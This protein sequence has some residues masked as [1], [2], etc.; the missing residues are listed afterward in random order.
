MALFVLMRSS[1]MSPSNKFRHSS[2]TL[3]SL[4]A[5]CL[6]ALGLAGCE[7]GDRDWTV[8]TPTPLAAALLSIDGTSSHDVWAVGADKGG[9]GPL[10]LHYDGTAWSTVATHSLGTLWWVHAFSDGTVY[11]AGAASTILRWDGKTWTR[12]KT[13]GLAAHTVFGLW[14]RSPNDAYAVGSVSGR[15]G[16]VWHYDGTGWSVVEVPKDLPGDTSEAPGFFK[17]CG[18]QTDVWVVGSHGNLLHAA[19]GGTFTAVKTPTTQTLFTVAANDQFM[20][21]V[22]GAGLGALI[23]AAPL[24]PPVDVTPPDAPLIQG[25]FLRPDGH[26]VASGADGTMYERVGGTWRR[27]DTGI[28]TAVQSLHAAWIDPDGGVWAVG[29]GVLSPALDGGVIFHGGSAIATYDPGSHVDGGTDLPPPAVCPAARIDPTPD[30][31]IARRWNEQILGA[32]RTDL[33]RPGVHARNLF[34]LS[35]AMWDAWAAYD[36]VADG[37]FVNERLTATDV[38][39][40]RNEAM[41]YAAYRV[42]DH[43]YAKQTGGAVSSA[44]FAAFMTKLGYDPADMS[45]TGAT[46]R[47]LGNRIGAAIIAATMNDGANEAANYADTTGWKASNP[48]LVID[49][50]GAAMTDPDHWQPLNIN[51]AETQNGIVIPSGVQGYVGSNWDLVTPFAM[52]RP[53]PGLPYYDPGAA[54][55]AAQPEMKDWLV[56]VIRR[57]AELDATDG[58]MIDTSPGA[59]GNNPLGTNDGHGRTLNPVTGQAY[60]PQMVARGD[61][62]RVLAEFWADGPKSETPPGHWNVL[63][64][65][66]V[67][68]ASFSRKLGGTGESLSPLEWDTKMYLALNSAVH[69]AAIT[70]WGIKRLTTCAR[71]ISLIRYL[72]GLGQASDPALPHYDAKGLPLVPGLVELITAESSAPGQRHAQL[73]RH[74]GELAV[75]GWRGEPGDRVN[76]VSG[77]AWIRALE[78]MPYQR[79]TFVTPAFPGFTSGHSTFSRAAAEVLTILTGSEFFP[80]GLAEFVAMPGAL[81]FEHGPTTAVHLQ[82]A[83][84]YDAADQAGQSRLWGGIHIQPDDFGGR[85]TGSLVG[86]DAAARALKFFDGSAVP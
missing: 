15:D 2:V 6:L 77:V 31:T 52:V 78:W 11:A 12:M 82:W 32:I 74:I 79:R 8:V 3:A 39:A 24:V 7:N 63:A 53:T 25:V 23:E 81:T 30:K 56:D 68:G 21:A 44:C 75:R 22:G 61:F 14:G 10:V 37:V 60:A 83:S 9:A 86:K 64:N 85:R 73:A 17:V 71:P 55:M 1:R 59:M 84:Y 35:T 48:P 28:K 49:L 67:G 13:P 80:N 76:E 70:S 43:R 72:A 16:F 69:D 62:G 65:A 42:L 36:T 27:I 38:T 18:N 47:A 33:P 5:P 54:P 41:S 40:A 57:E 46:S 50:P 26:G 51:V 20:V 58:Q 29:G 4:L 45:A 19:Q 66:V 34:H